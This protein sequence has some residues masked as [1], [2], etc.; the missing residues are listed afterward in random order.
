MTNLRTYT[1]NDLKYDQDGDTCNIVIVDHESLSAPLDSLIISVT[2]AEQKEYECQFNISE[3]T[4]ST[5]LTGNNIMEN[6]KGIPWQDTGV[7]HKYLIIKDVKPSNCIVVTIETVLSLGKS[8]HKH[9]DSFARDYIWNDNVLIIYDGLAGLKNQLNYDNDLPITVIKSKMI[10]IPTCNRYDIGHAVS[11]L[12]DKKALVVLEQ[13]KN[14]MIR[15]NDGFRTIIYTSGDAL[16]NLRFETPRGSIIESVKLSNPEGPE[17]EDV[18][19]TG[20]SLHD[21]IMS[22]GSN[23]KHINCIGSRIVELFIKIS[24]MP[25]TETEKEYIMTYDRAVYDAYIGY[26]PCQSQ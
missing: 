13:Q 2:G 22:I 14:H 24:N 10:K 6:G 8:E 17:D 16:C 25:N 1:I 26:Y 9:Q 21:N 19:N 7:Q 20:W 3:Y 12:V 15:H 11:V 4:I 18:Y 23:F 5:G